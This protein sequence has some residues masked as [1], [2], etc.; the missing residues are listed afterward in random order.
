MV[1]MNIIIKAIIVTALI[2][3]A[4]LSIIFYIENSRNTQVTDEIKQLEE[5][6]LDSQITL[7]LLQTGD[8][9]TY[10]QIMMTELEAQTEKLYPLFNQLRDYEK[11]SLI[12]QY[13]E[14]K[15]SFILQNL[16]YY[17]QHS[18]LLEKCPNVNYTTILYFYPDT[19]LCT[20]CSVQADVLTAL[21]QECPTVRVFAIPTDYDFSS[22]KTL[23]KEYNVTKTP[24]LVINGKI[25]V[26]T[27]KNK[28][29]LKTILG[30]C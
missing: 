4:N 14:T 9:K 11:A 10:C 29:E 27:V 19:T 28:E 2:F 6:Q 3:A 1:K 25:K 16:Q 24:T 12:T 18:Q 5:T 20:D 15:R 8:Q 23:I 17:S 26:E 21:R 30:K 7:S 22:I 13:Q